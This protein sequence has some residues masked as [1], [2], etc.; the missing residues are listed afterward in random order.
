MIREFVATFVYQDSGGEYWFLDKASQEQYCFAGD[1]AALRRTDLREGRDVWLMLDEQG[2]L[3]R[4]LP[5]L[6]S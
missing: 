1:A 2:R 6:Q 3:L 4:A 5:V